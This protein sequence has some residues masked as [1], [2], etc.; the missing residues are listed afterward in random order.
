MTADGNYVQYGAG[1]TG[2]EGWTNFDCSPTLQLQRLPVVGGWIRARCET[3]FSDPIRYGDIVRGL[4]VPDH[5]ATAVY[6]SHVLEHLSLRDLRT[7]L[8]HTHRILKPGGTFRMVLPDLRHMA[9]K[10]ARD[11]SPDA[12]ITFMRETLLGAETRPRGFMGLLRSWLGNSEHLWLWDFESLSRELVDAGFK[13]PRRVS[14]HDS[15]DRMFDAAER[16][17]RWRDA[18]GIQ[19]TA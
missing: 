19:C 6:C 3:K 16:A 5:S 18:L 1:A 13:N 15:G 14:Y 11:E 17:D 8:R 4:P 12:A 2:P 9:A 7:A 10:Y